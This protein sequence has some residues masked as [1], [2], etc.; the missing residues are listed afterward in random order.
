VPREPDR[1]VITLTC[2]KHLGQ[3]TS[4]T[5]H[6]SRFNSRPRGAASSVSSRRKPPPSGVGRRRTGHC[7]VLGCLALTRPL[8]KPGPPTSPGLPHAP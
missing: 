8:R 1:A 4:L 3:T 7:P 6:E 5:W 2:G